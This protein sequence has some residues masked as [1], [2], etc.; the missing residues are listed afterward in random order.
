[1]G[2]QDR[3]NDDGITDYRKRLDEEACSI[4][5]A[6]I[7]VKPGALPQALLIKPF[8]LY[9]MTIRSSSQ[10]LEPAE[11]KNHRANNDRHR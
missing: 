3:N 7:M 2:R 9:F 5:D 4:T 10:I 11:I 1:M 6:H 8:G